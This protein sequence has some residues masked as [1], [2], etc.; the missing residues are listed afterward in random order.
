MAEGQNPGV[1]QENVE[2]QGEQT[3]D[4]DFGHE[5]SRKN[6][7]GN[8]KKEKGDPDDS[9]ACFCAGRI[10]D[11]GFHFSTCNYGITPMPGA[12]TTKDENNQ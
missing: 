11:V 12:G 5:R 2:T 1:S 8:Q 10:D 9:V 3:E 6:V 4:Q 7:G